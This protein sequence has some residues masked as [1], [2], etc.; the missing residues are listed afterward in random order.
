M[1]YILSFAMTVCSMACLAQEFTIDVSQPRQTIRHFGASDAWSMQ[2]IGLWDN[3]AEQQKI[4]DWLFSTQNDE[5]GKPRGIGLSVWRFNLGAGSA[6]QG[7]D[8][9]I[10]PGTRTECFLTKDGTYDWS[11]QAGQRKFLRMAKER[12]VPH[13]LAFLNSAPVYFTQNGLAT[14]TGRGGT[15]NLKDDCYDDFAR[16]MATAVKGVEEH[17][18]IHFDYLCPVNE[19]DGH[20]NWLGPKQEGSPATNREIARLVRETGKEFKK[21][22]LTTQILVDESSDLRCLL[23]TH[24]TNW[25]RGYQIRT[26]FSKDSTKTYLGNVPNVPKLMVGHSYWT[27]TPVPY[28]RE[29]REQLRDTI[30]KYGLKFWQTELCIMGNDEEIGGGGGYDFTM[31]TAL[32]VARVIHHDLVFADA[33][34]WS[35]WRSVGEDYKD[36]LIRVFTNDHMKSGYAVDSRLMWALGNYSRFVRPGAVRYEVSSSA[37]FDPYGVMCSAYRNADGKWVAV[38]I[39]YSKALQNFSL[40]LSEGAQRQWQMY[41]TSDVSG[42]TLKPVGLFGQQTLLPPQS[43][44]TFV[45]K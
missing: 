16:F 43:I 21:Q 36:G 40:R 39:N 41:R 32:Y 37:Q 3:E 18:G 17:D 30:A 34:S 15:I 35:W 12:G 44:T 9:Q 27:N 23:A 8:S 38:V 6:E 25:E 24:E 26:F 10:Q 1:K 31:K 42:E 14:N 29:I 33:E 2:F 5:Q 20:W 19:P 28:M 45:E 22:H 11:K 4:A 13:F 7:K